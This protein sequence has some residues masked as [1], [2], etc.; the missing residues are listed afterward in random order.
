MSRKPAKRPPKL[1]DRVATILEEA[2]SSVV[3]TVNTRMVIA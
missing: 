1:F 2:R 3:R